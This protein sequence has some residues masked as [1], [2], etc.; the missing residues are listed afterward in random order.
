MS[1]ALTSYGS[2]TGAVATSFGP[3]EQPLYSR[4]PGRRAVSV[5]GTLQAPLDCGDAALPTYCHSGGPGK[6]HLAQAGRV[7]LNAH[8]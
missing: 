4:L 3:A 8:A 7:S 2:G 5:P 6:R 1:G